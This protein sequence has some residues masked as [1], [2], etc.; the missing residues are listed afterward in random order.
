[1]IEAFKH[2]SK[3][4]GPEHVRPKAFGCF[5]NAAII[6]Y[7]GFKVKRENEKGSSRFDREYH[8]GGSPPVTAVTSPQQAGGT[9]KESPT[10]AR[11]WMALN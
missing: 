6:S 2:L 9:E 11:I 8:G 10:G 1:M 5:E 4:L 7:S 3:V